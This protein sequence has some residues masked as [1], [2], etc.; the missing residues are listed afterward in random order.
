MP[1]LRWLA[2]GLAV[3]GALGVSA[4]AF[5][6]KPA[7]LLGSR[8]PI[9]A[10]PG[11]P[12]HAIP[13]STPTP[14]PTP[15]GPP[16]PVGVPAFQ[17]GMNVLLSG[18]D[19]D[20][21]R[22]GNDLFTRLTGLGV[23]SVAFAFPVYQDDRFATVVHRGQDTPDDQELAGLIDLAHAYR[24][25]VAVRPLLDEHSLGT[26]HWRGDIAP[27][28]VA[29]WF[30][31]Y[32]ALVGGIAQLAQ[33]HGAEVAVVGGEFDSMEVYTDGWVSLV[34]AIRS[35]FRGRLTYASNVTSAPGLQVARVRFWSA[36][37]FVGS[38]LYLQSSAPA[39]ASAAQLAESW[40]GGLQQFVAAARAAQRP[41]L[42]TE[43]GVRAQLGASQH[44]WVWDN[45]GPEDQQE[46]VTYYQAACSALHGQA[47]G[48]YW[49]QTSLDGPRDQSGFDPLGH[50][51]ED[52]L[53]SCFEGGAA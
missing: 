14:D 40:Q 42:L 27:R 36:L 18:S 13:A 38:D 19:P 35:V 8:P 12:A 4:L 50:P 44:P 29:A 43:I 52:Q 3:I 16:V 28:S 31:S 33:Q 22:K 23:N 30:A 1:V 15:P 2:F 45:G 7:A 17:G 47:V 48:L 46:Q 53:R 5:G 39:G 49:W 9:A 34:R 20:Y 26:G 41:I 21:V 25:A 11:P 24:M 37:D 10:V 32:T 6:L 51:A